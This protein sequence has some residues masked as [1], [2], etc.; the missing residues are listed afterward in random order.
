MISMCE[1]FTELFVYQLEHTSEEQ[2]VKRQKYQ[3]LIRKLTL[4]IR[5]LNKSN[6][7][8]DRKAVDNIYN[9]LLSLDGMG[10]LHGFGFADKKDSRKGNAEKESLTVMPFVEG[11][12]QVIRK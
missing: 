5:Q 2:E 11:K 7:L 4:F 10:N 9:F 3:K 8:D 6:R 12:N 1:A